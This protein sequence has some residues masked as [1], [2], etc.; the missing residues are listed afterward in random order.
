MVGFNSF[1]LS[2]S[3][4]CWLNGW[5]GVSSC[6]V[7]VVCA[8][9]LSSV[10]WRDVIRESTFGGQHTKKEQKGLYVGF[11]LFVCFEVMLFVSFF[12]AFLHSGLA[13]AVEVGCWFPPVGIQPFDPC[14]LP[15]V[16]TF[17]LICSGFWVN[18][19]MHALKSDSRPSCLRWLFF[20]LVLG[21]LFTLFQAFEYTEAPF[22]MSDSV[23][24]SCFFLITGFHGGHV[25]VGTIF[26]A[27]QW[28]RIWMFHFS[29][30]H[31]LGLEF[32]VWYWHFVDVIWLFVYAVVYIWGGWYGS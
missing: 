18:S 23:F 19:A 16:M 22:T 15:L 9:L 32:A 17:V 21:C 29:T 20:V 13:P 30:G 6:L 14:G 5:S 1:S 4:V 28:Y 2:L 26:L 7:S 25:I 31:H 12:W 8:L 10:W 11:V 27:V 24:G 3:L